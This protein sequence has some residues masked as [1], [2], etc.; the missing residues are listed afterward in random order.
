MKIAL[1]AAVE[2]LSAVLAQ[3]NAALVALD[4]VRA[5]GFLVAK[6]AATDS[7]ALAGEQNPGGKPTR[8]AAV[9]LRDLAAENRR[10]LERAIAV[11]GRVIAVVAR[12]EPRPTV[13]PRYGATGILAR[14]ARPAA[15]A[16]SARA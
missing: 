7:L 16:L 1:Q 11:Q 15:M 4:F 10:L 14:S 13:M 5:T 8:E 9:R 6:R 3:E 12:A 2:T